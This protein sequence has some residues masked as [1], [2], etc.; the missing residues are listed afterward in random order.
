MKKL[1]D[2]WEAKL[3]LALKTGRGKFGGYTFVKDIFDHKKLIGIIRNGNLDKAYNFACNLDTHCREMIPMTVWN[4]LEKHY[5]I[6]E[7]H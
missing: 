1:L 3:N 6:N 4:K 7:S 2:G 5:Y